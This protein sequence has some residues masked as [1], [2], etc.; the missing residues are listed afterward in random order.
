MDEQHHPDENPVEGEANP[1]QKIIGLGDKDDWRVL[2]G[3]PESDELIEDYSSAVIK[4]NFPHHGR[5]YVTKK[6]I[7]FRSNIFGKKSKVKL[8]FG[9]MLVLEK[10][11]I[12][13][14]NPAIEIKTWRQKYL[15]ASFVNRDRTF[16]VIEKAWNDSRQADWNNAI[17]QPHNT[18]QSA[19]LIDDKGNLR[20]E[21]PDPQA[22]DQTDDNLEPDHLGISEL[23]GE[24]ERGVDDDEDEWSESGDEVETETELTEPPVDVTVLE[25]VGPHATG[26]FKAEIP[27]SVHQLLMLI[28]GQDSDEFWYE[29]MK[30]TDR[31]DVVLGAWS[32]Y[33]GGSELREVTYIQNG[34]KAPPLL[35]GFPRSTRCIELQRRTIRS[36]NNALFESSVQTPDVTYGDHFT[37]EV[38]YELTGKRTAPVE[39]MVKDGPL[40]FPFTHCHLEVS[41]TIRW[42][43]SL[44]WM[45]KSAIEHVCLS[46]IKVNHKQWMELVKRTYETKPMGPVV[47]VQVE[48]PKP[49]RKKSIAIQSKPRRVENLEVENPSKAPTRA[50]D[51]TD[52]VPPEHQPEPDAPAPTT[53]GEGETQKDPLL[54]PKSVKVEPTVTVPSETERAKK[55]VK[56][57]QA[58]KTQIQIWQAAQPSLVVLLILILLAW[59][60]VVF[61]L[62]NLRALI[63]NGAIR[64]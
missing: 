42:I 63:E 31:T 15:F 36:T 20:M 54:A 38:R 61:E 8:C 45:I 24:E 64:M 25:P 58:D 52:A 18:D 32:Q 62:R 41:M 12:N 10:T 9:E 3:A 37:V 16:R 6:H 60:W 28:T 47:H 17:L 43:K 29:Y 14:I 4:K 7:F 51:Q 1:F 59:L 40:M 56:T 34:L 21:H 46:G 39:V 11:V 33:T 35:A 26:V 55:S 48:K 44:T 13:L 27:L 53:E 57:Q 30:V 22:S 19:V 49:R 2:F 50:E 5:M 23:I